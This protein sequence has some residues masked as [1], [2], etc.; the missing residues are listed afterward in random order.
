MKF[1][2]ILTGLFAC[3]AG[4]SLWAA[5][6]LNDLRWSCGGAS[7][8]AVFSFQK[9]SSLPSY[10][11]KFDATQN[12]L[13]VAFSQT[14]LPIADGEYTIDGS[15][16]WVRSVKIS[17][18]LNRKPQLLYV[19]FVTGGAIVSADN[20]VQLR[21]KTDF[22]IQFPRNKQPIS[23]AWDLKA[24][25]SIQKQPSRSKEPSSKV[26][27][28]TQSVAESVV[29][30]V[31]ANGL[32]EL[33]VVK[34]G[35]LE[36]LVLRFSKPITPSQIKQTAQRIFIPV[37]S[38]GSSSLYNVQGSIAKGV[39]WENGQLVVLLQ[40]K[41]KPVLIT[42][43][44]RIILQ[45]SVPISNRLETWVALPSGVQKS[46]WALPSQQ[47]SEE[48]L[49]AF[50]ANK[51]KSAALAI[52]S[53]TI[54]LRQREPVHVVVDDGVALFSEPSDKS[55]IVLNLSF[56]EKVT[57]LE[58]NGLFLKVKVS[59]RMGYVSKRQIA[60][61]TD[62]TLK[63]KERLMATIDPQKMDGI[64]VRFEI[65]GDEHVTYSSFGRRDPFIEVKGVTEDAINI[66][67]T[68]LAGIIW[69]AEVPMALLADTKIPGVSYTVREGDKILNGKVLKITQK[70]VLFQINEFGV[71]RRYSMTLPDKYGSKK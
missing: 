28:S 55:T 33:A 67:Q 49:E 37:A 39:L 13:R 54:Q 30:S 58:Q 19:D 24:I 65:V 27:S 5:S 10:Y 44:E 2:I 61:D 70:D 53:G 36:Q 31:F 12:T 46:A 45:T 20:A 64:A 18:D 66:D 50:A 69:E 1:K 14:N 6:S 16:P 29:P 35:G 57:V 15:S 9:G 8:Q 71:S 17:R 60:L 43:S 41:A 68:E 21:G 42:Q 59:D 62:L 40:N 38:N 4:S 25:A 56:G 3:F 11:Q 51:Q 52:G 7:C 23:K 32:Q 34:G 26:A 63:Q 47:E 22:V 48:G